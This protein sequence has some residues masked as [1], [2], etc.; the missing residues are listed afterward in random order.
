MANRHESLAAEP[1]ALS[2]RAGDA[3][4]V[5]VAVLDVFG[6]PVTSAAWWKVRCG[7]QK[8]GRNGLETVA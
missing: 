1:S 2:L 6:N 7:S 5:T 8:S 4:D 3:I